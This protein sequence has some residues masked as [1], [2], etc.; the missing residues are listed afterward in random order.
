MFDLNFLTLIFSILIIILLAGAWLFLLTTVKCLHA[1]SEDLAA[2]LLKMHR[3]AD[4][5]DALSAPPA[6]K[7]GEPVARE[8]TGPCELTV[9]MPARPRDH[10]P[11][12]TEYW[13]RRN[14][15]TCK[16]E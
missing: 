15:D 4:D 12:M 3:L 2:N 6:S 9:T 14:T 1:I 13:N 10:M 11:L 8:P 16:E 5:F 7:P